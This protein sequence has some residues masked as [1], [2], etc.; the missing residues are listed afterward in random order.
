MMTGAPGNW[1]TWLP[2][3]PA[4]LVHLPTGLMLTPLLYSARAQATSLLQPGPD[5][6]FGRRDLDG[7]SISFDSVFAETR[8]AWRYQFSECDSLAL[9]WRCTDHGEWGLRYW[10]TLCLQGRN[11]TAFSYD[12]ATGILRA[13]L[14]EGFLEVR[15]AKNPLLVT[16]HDDLADLL[17]EL[18]E[19]GYFYLASRDREGPLIALRFN[20]EEAPAMEVSLH[21]AA[22][23][24]TPLARPALPEPVAQEKEPVGSSARQEALQAIYD[25]MAWNHAYDSINER[26][27]TLLTRF[28]N[29]QKF[30]GF[31][32]WLNDVLYNGLMWGLFDWDAALEN[33]ESAFAWQTEAGNF[34]CLVTGNDAWLDRSQPPIAAFIVWS[35]YQLGEGRDFLGYAYPKLLR[36]FDW[37]WRCRKL[38]DSGL[39]AYGTS[40][41]VGRGLYKGTKLAAKDESSMDNSPVHDPAPFDEKSGLLLAADVGLNSLLALEGEILAKM[42]AELG[43]GEDAE[44]LEKTSRDHKERIRTQLWDPARQVFANRLQS[45]AFVEA[46]APT[47]FYPLAA[48]A[49]DEEQVKALVNGYLNNPAKFGGAPGLPSV[50]RDHEAYH[51]NVY[52]R[53]RIWGPLNFWVYQG[54][55]RAGRGAE[56]SELSAKSWSLFAAGWNDRLCGENYNAENGAILDQADTDGFYSWGAL[57]PLLAVGEVYDTTP[58][59]GLSLEPAKVKKSLGP[60]QSPAGRMEIREAAAGWQL[61]LNGAPFLEGNLQG[62]MRHVVFAPDGFSARLP[63]G[64][65]G[66]RLAFSG[67]KLTAVRLDGEE[68]SFQAAEIILPRRQAPQD[69]RVTWEVPETP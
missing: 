55:R 25:V 42:A 38:G 8:L 47:S 46:L 51:D 43:H 20:L 32:V 39:V 31:G 19:K 30:G 27:Y 17:R 67:K 52:W 48:G 61:F 53:G 40:P 22:G 62:R 14:K 57:L 36:N 11:S 16:F 2:E 29:Q 10:V 56:A 66:E 35:L 65:A 63:E 1:N 5:I 64:T 54:L 34:P 3:C 41:D 21:L 45:G 6:R 13:Q 12:E 33:L 9:R 23:A 37:W 24:E 26:P 18:E 58:W 28:W 44:R 49:A 59:E 7:S 4:A 60:M 50:A 68:L 15:A 69:L